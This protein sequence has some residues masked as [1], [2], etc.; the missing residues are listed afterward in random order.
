ML[1][2]PHLAAATHG[3]DLPSNR[4]AIIKL[5]GPINLVAVSFPT[6]F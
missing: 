5:C 2:I 1:D 3:S 4:P 6:D